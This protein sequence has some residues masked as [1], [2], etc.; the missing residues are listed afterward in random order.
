MI[1]NM[2]PNQ[3]VVSKLPSM[4][5]EAQVLLHDCKNSISIDADRVLVLCNAF[6]DLVNEYNRLRIGLSCHSEKKSN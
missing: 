4:M 2:L 3:E 5:Y 1:G 6:L